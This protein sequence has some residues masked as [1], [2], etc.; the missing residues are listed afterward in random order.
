MD[1]VSLSGHGRHGLFLRGHGHSYNGYG[2]SQ[3]TWSL[4]V[5]MV[6]L[7]GHGLSIWTWSVYVDMVSLC[8]HDLS[9]RTWSLS[10]NIAFL[11]GQ[12]LSQWTRWTWFL[13]VID[14]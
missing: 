9:N 1:M 4:Y 5:N 12:D 13:S 14:S 8:G 10:V 6:S 3:R 7:C 2:L 11:R